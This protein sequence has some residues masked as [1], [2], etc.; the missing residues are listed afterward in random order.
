V[1]AF[2]QVKAA[3]GERFERNGVQFLHEHLKIGAEYEQY[4]SALPKSDRLLITSIIVSAH[5]LCMKLE[6]MEMTD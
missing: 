2:W 6:D 1:K 4:L 5:K 3:F